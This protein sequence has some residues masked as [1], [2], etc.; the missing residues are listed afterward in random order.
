M[1]QCTLFFINYVLYL[2][3]VQVALVAPLESLVIPLL[4]KRMLLVS[5]FF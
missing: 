2:Q 3:L 5:S 4:D 1:M